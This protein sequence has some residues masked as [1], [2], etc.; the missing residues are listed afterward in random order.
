MRGSAVTFHADLNDL[1]RLFEQIDAAMSLTF[2]D[3]LSPLNQESRQFFRAS[4][5]VGLLE[6]K[7]SVFQ[8]YL[9]VTRPD[10]PI[11]SQKIVMEDGSGF[12]I[13]IS[14]IFNP[15]GIQLLLGEEEPGTKCLVPS[16]FSTKAETNE[17]R[18]LMKELKKQIVRSAIY[19]QGSYVFPGARAKHEQGWRLVGGRGYSTVL[20]IVLPPQ[21]D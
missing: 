10:T 7:E 19:V 5:L 18:S 3:H 2:T 16:R 4:D 1:S 21:G 20:D 15:E 12:K 6:R 14:G 9:L 11:V 8:E 17:A 13:M